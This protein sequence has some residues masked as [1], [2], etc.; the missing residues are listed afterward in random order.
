MKQLFKICFVL[1]LVLANC[2]SAAAQESFQ[3]ATGQVSFVSSQHVY[4]KFK[5]TEGINKNDTLFIENNAVLVPALLV[6]DLSSIS[7]VT[8]PLNKTI[9]TVGSAVIARIPVHKPV[10]E[11]VI[12]KSKESVAVVSEVIGQIQNGEKKTKPTIH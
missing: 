2:N 7:C 8:V 1:I 6:S 11:V 3:T 10:P 5:N 12:E 4:V 9:L